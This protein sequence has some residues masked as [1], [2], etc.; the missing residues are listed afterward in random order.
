MWMSYMGGGRQ[1]WSMAEGVA[2]LMDLPVSIGQFYDYAPATDRI[3]YATTFADHGAGPGNISVSD[4]AVLDVSTGSVS[5]LIDDRV[6]E[7]QWA[8]NGE[9]FAYVL[10]TDTTYELHWRTADGADRLLASDV[11]FT[12]SISPAGDR[13]AFT[14]ESGY[15]NPAA[16]GLYV[17]PV[18][19]GTAIR[20][21]S[22]D[23]SGTGSI[24]DQPFWSPNGESVLLPLWSGPETP[25]LV[26]ARSD[27]GGEVNLTIDPAYASNWWYTLGIPRFLWHPDGEHLIALPAASHETMGGPS[28]LVLY[29]LDLATNTLTDAVM[30]GEAG[31]LIAW[32]VPGE[33]VWVMSIDGDVQSMS[34]P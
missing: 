7:A 13:V 5:R 9:D 2:Y 1:I 12:W 22:A 34:L 20:V 8:P 14:R 25:R 31:A 17:V 10:A 32:N 15:H 26:L 16:L 11:N 19:G 24:D 28:P 3:L 29:R 18:S 21:S 33:S 27:G 23:K 6:V 30:F 4:L